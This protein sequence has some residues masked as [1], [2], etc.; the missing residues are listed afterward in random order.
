METK[1]DMKLPKLYIFAISHFSEKARFILDHSKFSYEPFFL[2]PGEH[3]SVVKEFAK[4]SYVPILR[5]EDFLLQGSNAIIEHL[6]RSTSIP[7]IHFEKEME[8]VEKIDTMIGY[9]LQPIVYSYLLEEPTIV[10]KMFASTPNQ[11]VLFENFKLIALGL[12][13]R[14]KIN[15]SNIAEQK[16]KFL[17][18]V[19]LLSDSYSKTPYL[20]GDQLT[21]ADIT[22]A[23]LI[24]PLFFPKEH[25]NSHWFEGVEFPKPMVEWVKPLYD[26]EYYRRVLNIYR[27]HR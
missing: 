15:E 19:E 17:E 6:H 13:R 16:K 12:K 18:G 11:P 10:G 14:Y 21:I 1:T 5:G 7:S 2:T 22:A 26:T 27:D 9:P 3:I 4:E 8:W 24:S 25:P 23:S 20:V